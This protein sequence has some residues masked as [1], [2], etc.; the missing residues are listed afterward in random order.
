MNWTTQTPV[1]QI[2]ETCVCGAQFLSVAKH[3][4][5]RAGEARAFREAHGICRRNA[6][7]IIEARQK[8][9]D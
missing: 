2:Q 8:S 7:K 6:A 1:E 3:E 5:E 4:S 9:E